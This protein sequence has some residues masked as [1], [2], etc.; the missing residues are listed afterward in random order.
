MT[1]NI[2]EVLGHGERLDRASL[3]A[4]APPEGVVIFTS[5][6]ADDRH[7]PSLMLPSLSCLVAF[8]DGSTSV[9]HQQPCIIRCTGELL[10]T[11]G[12]QALL[13]APCRHEPDVQPAHNGV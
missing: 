9:H 7:L 5:T 11:P 10:R 4:F 3:P 12:A 1:R 8:D 6:R 13:C 2:A